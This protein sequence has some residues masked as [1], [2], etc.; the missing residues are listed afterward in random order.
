MRHEKHIARIVVVL[1]F[2]CISLTASDWV[3]CEQILPDEY[4]VQGIVRYIHLPNK[5]P[6]ISS[7]ENSL[8]ASC[9]FYLT[10]DAFFFDPLSTLI[11]RI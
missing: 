1:V 9:P 7:P 4:M 6:Y 3:L 5:F 8:N 2:L 11:L 10:E